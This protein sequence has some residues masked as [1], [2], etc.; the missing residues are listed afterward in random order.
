M[1]S[2]LILRK[3]LL[4]VHC[5]F[6]CG[7]II[8]LYT[9]SPLKH[10]LT[11]CKITGAHSLMYKTWGGNISVQ[12]ILSENTGCEVSSNCGRKIKINPT[13]AECGDS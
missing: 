4:K 11:G 9:C 10:Q 12:L 13:L 3:K 6:H 7:H 1:A 8:S 2:D 5:Y